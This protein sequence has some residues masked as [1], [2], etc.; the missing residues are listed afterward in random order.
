M[1]IF[2]TVN[3]YT[4]V[5]IGSLLLVLGIAPLVFPKGG[6]WHK[7]IGRLYASLYVVVLAT[8]IIGAIFF[9]S[10][11]ALMAITL[12]ASYGYM[13]GIRAIKIKSSGPQIID[14]LM[15]I[16]VIII[17]ASMLTIMSRNGSASWSPI[18]GYSVIGLTITH[19]L[20]DL[21]RNFWVA[22]WTKKVWPI[23][24]GYKMIGSYFALASAASG[25]L[26]RDFQPWSQIAPSI[27]GVIISG[28]FIYLYFKHP[29]SL[30]SRKK[31]GS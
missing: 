3:I 28:V 16:G 14:N 4:H 20:Y 27:I 19:S 5:I 9:R 21:S 23:D 17:G 31:I 13:S 12:A 11:P 7:R 30:M 2:Q 26:I 22:I 6:Y 8:A 25:N 10:Q 24:H 29:D 18:M 1:D 15:A